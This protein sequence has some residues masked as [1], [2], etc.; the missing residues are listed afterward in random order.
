M[1]IKKKISIN[2]AKSFEELN[3]F[4]AQKREEKIK[5]ISEEYR[6]MNKQTKT[7]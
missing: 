5:K 4:V 2:S 3:W 1:C 7:K 6:K